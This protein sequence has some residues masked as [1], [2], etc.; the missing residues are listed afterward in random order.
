MY[1]GVCGSGDS[2]VRVAVEEMRWKVASSMKC[3]AWS[4][5]SRIG[6]SSIGRCGFLGGV[7]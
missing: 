2:S 3:G 1:S 7:S 4:F 5:G 6:S